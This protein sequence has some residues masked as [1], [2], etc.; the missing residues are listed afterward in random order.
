LAVDRTKCLSQ[1]KRVR[2]GIAFNDAATITS[3][4][5]SVDSFVDCEK[6]M[7][8]AGFSAGWDFSYHYDQILFVLI[9]IMKL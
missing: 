4:T 6:K 1:P 9:F 8:D 3:I 7:D 2:M 5:L